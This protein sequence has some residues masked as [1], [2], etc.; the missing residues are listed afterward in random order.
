MSRKSE[1]ALIRARRKMRDRRTLWA[2]KKAL[3]R[4]SAGLAV[5]GAAVVSL[6]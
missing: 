3:A 5:L 2:I 4:F 6:G 1:L